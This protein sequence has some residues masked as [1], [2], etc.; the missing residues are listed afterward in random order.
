MLYHLG[1]EPPIVFPVCGPRGPKSVRKEPVLVGWAIPTALILLAS[2]AVLPPAEPP[3]AA[4]I[5]PLPLPVADE[6]PPMQRLNLRATFLD[7]LSGQELPRVRLDV[8]GVT[9]AI[10]PDGARTALVPP[11]EARTLRASG[12]NYVPLSWSGALSDGARLTFRMTPSIVRMVA[13]G[14]S[15]TAGVNVSEPERFVYKLPR[16]LRRTH[17]AVRLDVHARGRSGDTYRAARERLLGDV[18]SVRPDV[19]LVAFG[20]N[21]VVATPL[22]DFAATV[23]GVLAPLAGR[24]RV[25]VADI[26]YKARWAGDW[27]AKAAPFNRVIAESAARHGATLVSW[28]DRFKEASDRGN[29]D[30]FYHQAPYDL[31]APDSRTQ[32]DLHPNG[33]GNDLMAA[34]CAEVLSAWLAPEASVQASAP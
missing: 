33:A 18:L 1:R 25:M 5:D 11:A 3:P 4:P 21:D 14:D 13:F 2:C 29:W 20:T 24:A 31:R 26:P 17:G 28:S 32:G 9:C 19:V 15:L 8:D 10:A 23:D 22:R 12:G 7:A 30:V 16:L 27:N 34:A 6:G